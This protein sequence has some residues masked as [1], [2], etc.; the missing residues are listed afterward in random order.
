VKHDYEKLGSFYLGKAVD[1][2]SGERT[3][4]L[5]LYD[6]RDLTTHGVII[7]MT[8]SGKTGLGVSLL[9]EAAMDRIPVIAVDPKGD[10]TNLL[11][12]FPDLAPEDFRPWI[13]ED[14]AR[15]RGVDPDDYA[16]QQAELWRTGL[17]EWHQDGER[18]RRL[19]EHADFAIYTPGSSAGLPVSVLRSF[20]AP[21]PELVADADGFRDRIQGAVTGLLGLLGLDADPVRSRDYILLASILDDAWRNGRSLD[22]GGL[23]Q[24]IQQPPFRRL[25]VMELESIYPA[26]DRFALAMRLNSLLASPGFQGWMEGEP[27]DINAM[28]YTPKGQPRLTVFSI[29]HLGDAERMFFVTM[30]LSAVLGWMRGQPGTTSLRAIVYMDEIF[31]FFPPSGN[32]PS[33][34]PML[35]LLKQARAFGVGMVLATQNP[36]DLDYKGLGNTGTWFIGRLQTDR[37]KMRV[38]EALEGAMA[39]SNPIPRQQLDRMISGL[40]KRVFLMHN[41]HRGAPTLFTT[42]WAMSYLAGPMTLNQIRALMDPHKSVADTAPEA[43]PAPGSAAVEAPATAVRPLLPATIRQFFV[44]AFA[45]IEGVRYR[46]AVLA[47]LDARYTSARHGVEESRNLQVLVELLDGPLAFGTDRAVTVDLPVEWLET[48]PQEGAAFESL[49]GEATEPRGYDRWGRELVRWVQATQPIT[50]L[51]SKRHK[52]VSRPGETER[53]FR[54]RLADLGREARDAQAERLRK[55]YEP[56]FRTLQERL[57]RAEQAAEKRSAQSKQAMLNVALS[58]AG[59]VLGAAG[60]GKGRRAA[61]GLLG[62]LLGGGTSRATGAVRSA[63]RA[64][65][66]RKDV[67]HAEETVA[68]VQ[69]TIQELEH[70]LQDELARLDDSADNQ[71]ELEQILVR[72]ALSAIAVRLTA[73]AWLPYGTDASGVSIPLWR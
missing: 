18:I 20:D 34:G 16:A 47:A 46:P 49:P 41:V 23:I 33:K 10:L 51:D 22:L 4:D 57:R 58:A 44:P 43:A 53:E 28:L 36:V 67:A 56:R 2:E 66:T 65:Q 29:A 5:V 26:K 73:L 15:Q 21:P 12:T 40:G 59:A 72:P 63:G 71:E 54:M 8:G 13:N 35:T 60:G 62:A 19:R 37:D 7:G 14:S 27:L 52:A 42:R 6:S 61:G 70:E 17:A 39:G 1:L 3:E 32:P 38:L 50:L 24:A 69:A 45:R 30:L 55:K 9:E 31:G 48:E 68:T 11:L 64:A 25:G